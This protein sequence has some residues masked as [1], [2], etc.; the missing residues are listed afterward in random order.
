MKISK[1]LKMNFLKVA[2]IALG[3]VTI[4]LF[5]FFFNYALL[6]SVYSIG[7]SLHFNVKYYLL[8]N[9][10]VGVIAG[11]LA[12]IALVS[13]NSRLFRRRSF[14]FAIGTTLISYVVIF[15]LVTFVA[16][17]SNLVREYGLQGITYD[18]VKITLGHVFDLAL[19]TYFILWGFITLAT[20]F[21]LQVND[22]FGPGML[23]KFLAG[24]YHQP[25]KE[26]RIFMFM[27]MRSS[28]T[29]AEKIGNE[30]YFHLLNDL[31]SDIADT[32]LNNEGEIYQYV[33]DEIVISWSIKKGVRNAN[34]LR[35]FTEIQEKLT[36]LR[37]IYEQK[38]KVMP[39]FKAGLHYGL[40][41]AGEIGV[42]KKDIIYSGD[43][44]NTTARIQEQCNQYSV[45]ILISTETFN[46]LSDTNGYELI[47]LG[48]IELRGKERKI[49][50]NTV[51][52]I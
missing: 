5:I 10:F 27:D 24:N 47:T 49:D 39:E 19:L 36:V 31:F 41:M 45:D 8:T 11:L 35:C 48:N 12:G 28:T 15:I 40:V 26:E 46:L 13:V 50:L 4:N 18:T 2:I 7:P 9:I 17:F 43:V 25:K 22:K 37:P 6:N 42:I 38:Y 16:T 51:R 1:Y 32:I 21:L 44:L 3:Y 34:C 23:L 30:K 14:K 29:I 52:T 33:G 20:L